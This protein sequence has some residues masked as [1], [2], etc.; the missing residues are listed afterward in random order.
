MLEKAVSVFL[1]KH[2]EFIENELDFVGMEVDVGGI[3]CDLL[4]RKGKTYYIVEVKRFPRRDIKAHRDKAQL[5]AQQFEKYLI[6][7]KEPEC[8]SII[9]VLVTTSESI[10]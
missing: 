5:Y 6:E 1:I 8:E 4:F 2:P 10:C 9:P 3:L 7:K